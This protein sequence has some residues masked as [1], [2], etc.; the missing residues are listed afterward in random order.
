MADEVAASIVD[1]SSSLSGLLFSWRRFLAL[2]ILIYLLSLD[3]RPLWV[4]FLIG[5]VFC[6]IFQIILVVGFD[7][8]FDLV[9]T[10]LLNW[11]EF[12]LFFVRCRFLQM[13]FEILSFCIVLLGPVVWIGLFSINVLNNFDDLLVI[14]SN[15][16]NGFTHVRILSF[17]LE[18]F[19]KIIDGH[20]LFMYLLSLIK[21]REYLIGLQFLWRIVFA[22]F[23]QLY[24]LIGCQLVV[25]F[26]FKFFDD[27]DFSLLSNVGKCDSV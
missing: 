16:H 13:K 23:I 9:F 12:F 17:F 10:I 6:L 14:N 11:R 27:V 20:N 3:W 2:E 1:W 18:E 19:I 7:L 5:F 15:T 21:I 22:K 26:V 25:L 8:E 4:W 24:H